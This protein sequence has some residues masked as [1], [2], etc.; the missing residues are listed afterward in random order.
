LAACG[1]SNEDM[2]ID[3]TTT[4]RRHRGKRVGVASRSI[5]HRIRR[6]TG[7]IDT[8]PDQVQVGC[9]LI[10]HGCAAGNGL[11]VIAANSNNENTKYQNKHTLVVV[12]CSSSF[13]YKLLSAQR[14]IVEDPSTFSVFQY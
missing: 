4:N 12:C 5:E 3:K 7:R 2:R 14:H 8:L 1:Y 13:D 6:K 10:Q 9:R 11:L